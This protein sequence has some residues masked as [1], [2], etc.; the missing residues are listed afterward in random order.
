MF[1]DYE[2]CRDAMRSGCSKDDL[3]ALV[4]A[5]VRRKKQQHAG[6]QH[7]TI[8]HILLQ[9]RHQ[10]PQ[11]ALLVTVCAALISLLTPCSK[12]LLKKLTVTQLVKKLSASYAAQKVVTPLLPLDPVLSQMNLVHTL[13]SHVTVYYSPIYA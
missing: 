3:L 6:K 5:T 4:G 7:H 2:I 10:H 13:R 8:T 11:C 9:L 1:Q 12:V